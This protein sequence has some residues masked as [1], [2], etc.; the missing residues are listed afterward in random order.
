MANE[1]K[2]EETS[3]DKALETKADMERVLSDDEMEAISGG[4]AQ[5]GHDVSVNEPFGINYNAGSGLA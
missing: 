1:R 3:V 5:P 4:V 2:N